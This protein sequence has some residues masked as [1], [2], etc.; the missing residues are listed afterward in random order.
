[1][2]WTPVL[3]PWSDK[4]VIFLASFPL[5]KSI[6]LA[7]GSAKWALAELAVAFKVPLAIIHPCTRDGRM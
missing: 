2:A 6:Y 1:M 7:A 4:N 5:R 3:H